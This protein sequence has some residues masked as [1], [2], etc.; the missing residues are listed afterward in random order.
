MSIDV[1]EKVSLKMRRVVARDA[2]FA[3][4]GTDAGQSPLALDILL[5]SQ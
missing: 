1:P 2:P 4:L 5:D 3:R